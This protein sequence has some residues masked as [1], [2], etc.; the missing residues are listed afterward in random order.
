MQMWMC[1]MGVMSAA[2]RAWGF[3]WWRRE[4]MMVR[5]IV[6]QLKKVVHD[7]VR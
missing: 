2:S 7:D 1:V 5:R 6:S 4:S 3:R